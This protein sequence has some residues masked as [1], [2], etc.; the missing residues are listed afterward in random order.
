MKN[1]I[2]GLLVFM[3]TTAIFADPMKRADEA[4]IYV[5]NKCGDPLV[6]IHANEDGY[7]V[8]NVQ[9]MIIHPDQ[10]KELR[11]MI[12]DL[13]DNDKVLHVISDQKKCKRI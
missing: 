12:E 3:I 7:K 10:R 6:L 13:R 4:A 8:I 2:L 1:I 11:N 5:S 9:G